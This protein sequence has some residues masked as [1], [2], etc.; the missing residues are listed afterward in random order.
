ML[1]LETGGYGAAERSPGSK[2][3]LSP[4]RHIKVFL[5]YWTYLTHL[6]RWA[7]FLEIV[8][9]LWSECFLT[10]NQDLTWWA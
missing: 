9:V 2:K 4:V 7:N 3:E 8:S 6:S 1:Y 10:G 5:T